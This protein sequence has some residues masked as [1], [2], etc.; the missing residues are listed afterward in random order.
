MRPPLSKELW[1]SD[2]PNV[3]KTLRFKQ[4]N[5]KERS[6]YF[7]PPSFYVSAQDLPHVENGGVAVLTGK[8]VVQLDVRGNVARLN[9]GSQITYEKCLIA[10][11]G[12]PRSLSAIDRA[13]AK[14]KSRTTLFRKIEDFRTLEKI[15]R[16]V[17]SI[18]IIGG[19][20]LGSELAC[21]LGRKGEY[22]GVTSIFFLFFFLLLSLVL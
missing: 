20:F 22:W 19:G 18:T 6:I 7:Q 2:D 17:K 9:D 3:T 13:G 16:E 14:V 12:T 5:G 11:G 10:T 21:A 4:W 15:S 1:F 8:K